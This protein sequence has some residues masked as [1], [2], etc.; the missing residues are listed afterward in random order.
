MNALSSIGASAA[1]PGIFPVA[2]AGDSPA[3]PVAPQSEVAKLIQVLGALMQSGKAGA[4]QMLEGLD[5]DVDVKGSTDADASADPAAGDASNKEAAA[6]LA[7][8]PEV[9]AQALIRSMLA[10]GS[11]RAAAQL[12]QVADQTAAASTEAGDGKAQ[13]AQVEAALEDANIDVAALLAA[14]QGKTA[15]AAESSDT[16]KTAPEAK[17]SAKLTVVLQQQAPAPEIAATQPV[18]VPAKA[19]K[20]DTSATPQAPEAAAG[21]PQPVAIEQ[22]AQEAP[23]A[24]SRKNAA[25]RNTGKAPLAFQLRLTPETQGVAAEVK[26]PTGK[27]GDASVQ[28]QA[29]KTAAAPAVIPVRSEPNAEAPLSHQS[30]AAQDAVEAEGAPGSAFQTPQ[31]DAKQD[32]GAPADTGSGNQRDAN[33]N[34]K[35]DVIE[36]RPVQAAPRAA[37]ASNAAP[38]TPVSMPAPAAATHTAPANPHSSAP[39]D[40]VAALRNA[41]S[42]TPIT[43]VKPAASHS[44]PEIALRIARPDA[45]PV[46]I[47]VVQ[48]AGQVR[49]D[50]HTADTGLQTSLRQDLGSLVH[51]LEQ[52]G[53]RAEA[54][55][56]Q[57]SSLRTMTF[58]NLDAGVD[59]T[60]VHQAF[61][62]QNHANDREGQPDSGRGQHSSQQ[63]QQHQ[64]RRQPVARWMEVL[65]NVA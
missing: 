40:A 52:T 51:S 65:E 49:V 16:K 41:D 47:R 9:I 30:S 48:R 31:A 39:A 19:E 56:P 3:A 28:A 14:A 46:D 62:T 55:T 10:A 63:Q 44:T 15:E 12:A 53:Y 34:A 29:S 7:A 17:E 18:P 13:A 45:S 43:D 37:A 38:Q 23:A 2:T 5:I 35:R 50:V 58:A 61:H 6:P 36:F 32:N 54:F 4:S 60:S 24:A 57:D 42:A 59:R 22:P 25:A 20:P 1:L 33:S 11:A 8:P 27:E 21:G 64:Q 26:A